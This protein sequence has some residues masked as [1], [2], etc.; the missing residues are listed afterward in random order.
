MVNKMDSEDNMSSQRKLMDGILNFMRDEGI[1]SHLRHTRLKNDV[2]H[3]FLTK[4]GALEQYRKRKNK[5]NDA[6]R[7]N[8]NGE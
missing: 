4:S 3:W 2:R 5:L 8:N 7:G 1:L 6:S